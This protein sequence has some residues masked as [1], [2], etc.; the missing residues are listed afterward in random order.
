M[1]AAELKPKKPKPSLAS[2]TAGPVRAFKDAK[3]WEAW[4]EKNQSATDGLW[5]RIAKKASGKKSITHPEALEIALCYGWIDG[6]RRPENGTTYLQRFVP[7]RPRSMWSKINRDKALGLIA[8]GRMKPAGLKEVELARQDGRWEAA[9][10]SPKNAA[11]HPDFQKALDK[12]PRASEFFKTL[13]AANRYAIL[14]RIQTARKPEA[15][16]ER[17]RT[18]VEMLEKGKT[19]H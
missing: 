19:L 10:D 1:R 3:A 4:L 9:Y 6:L 18:F 13:S 8:G 2:G 15:R 7:R 16:T 12:N 17:I 14:W 5:M 11:I